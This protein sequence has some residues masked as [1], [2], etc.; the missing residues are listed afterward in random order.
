MN[1]FQTWSYL[2]LCLATAP[3]AKVGAQNYGAGFSPGQGCGVETEI[4]FDTSD[5]NDPALPRGC[6]FLT[7]E[8]M[9]NLRMNTPR[10]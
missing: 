2:L 7:R 10:K 1:K 9:Q 8:G 5:S 3:I 6:S 4:G